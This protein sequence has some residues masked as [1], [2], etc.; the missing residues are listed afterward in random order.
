MPIALILEL[1]QIAMDLAAGLASGKTAEE[2]G[3]S[4]A[5]VG[6]ATKTIAAH[7]VLVGAPM[8]PDSVKFEA[9][10]A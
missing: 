7:Q 1:S 6:L 5:L 8:D 10:I 3:A 4:A 2:L 9:Q